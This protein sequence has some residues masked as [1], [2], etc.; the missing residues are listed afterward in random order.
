MGRFISIYG[1]GY[2]NLHEKSPKK[3]IPPPKKKKF[4]FYKHFNK[5]LYQPP[6]KK[7]GT[8]TQRQS[9][10]DSLISPP[11]D[12]YDLNKPRNKSD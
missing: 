2:T 11:V 12:S 3:K 4:S 9:Y 7:A 5:N 8:E 1:E 6:V 10:P